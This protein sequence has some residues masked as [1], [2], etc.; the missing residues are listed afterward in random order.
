MKLGERKETEKLNKL[1]ETVRAD[2]HSRQF[3]AVPYILGKITGNTAISG[4]TNRWEYSWERADIDG[5]RA[6]ASRAG[7]L[8]YFGTA[9][10][11]I[12]GGNTSSIV[13]PGVLVTNIPFGFTVKPI[14]TGCFVLLFP[15]R[16]TT[17]DIQWVFSCPNAIDGIC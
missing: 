9:L 12:E 15:Q 7:E 3:D 16:R 14:A 1:A 2:I 5:S 11:V 13:M 10:N 17:R 6:F 8:R 4:A